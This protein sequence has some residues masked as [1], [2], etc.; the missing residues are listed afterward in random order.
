LFSGKK[1]DMP[2]YITRIGMQQLQK[3][4]AV[5]HEERPKVMSQVAKARELGDLSENAEYHAARERQRQI[6]GELDH[7]NRRAASLTVIDTDQIPKD[8][9][10]FGARVTLTDCDE[11]ETLVFLL[12]GVDEVQFSYDDGVERLSVASPIGRAMIGKR[13][14]ET[15]IAKVPKGDRTFTVLEIA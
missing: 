7:L 4:L 11:D 12:V 6:D 14:G 9:I 2:E 13:V 10:R 15:F 8:A 5:L 1:V 3:R